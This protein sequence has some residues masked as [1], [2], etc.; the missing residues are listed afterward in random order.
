MFSATLLK[1]VETLSDG[2]LY[3][4]YRGLILSSCTMQEFKDALGLEL[5]R[6]AEDARKQ[7]AASETT[8]GTDNAN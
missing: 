7:L 3:E 6:R 4:L 1:E 5:G 2:T 8:E